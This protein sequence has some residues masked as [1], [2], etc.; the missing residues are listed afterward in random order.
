METPSRS[1]IEDLDALADRLAGMRL[2]NLRAWSRTQ[3]N[4]AP[5]TWEALG[6]HILAL[7]EVL[8]GYFRRLDE[9]WG[10]TFRPGRPIL[11]RDGVMLETFQLWQ[12]YYEEA[13]RIGDGTLDAKRTAEF[14]RRVWSCLVAFPEAHE[15]FLA[16]L[17]RSGLA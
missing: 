11:L 1:L 7:Y 16:E 3:M 8:D 5:S 10:S 17:E 15:A 6:R 14:Q 12:V 4:G 2:P 13:Q 9:A